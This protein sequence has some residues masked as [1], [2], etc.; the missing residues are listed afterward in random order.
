MKREVPLPG[1]GRRYLDIRRLLRAQSVTQ[2]IE[3]LALCEAAEARGDIGG[4]VL[5]TSDERPDA[6]LLR[7]MGTAPLID[8]EADIATASTPLAIAWSKL[9]S[10][11]LGRL[12]FCRTLPRL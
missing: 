1:N 6:E 7:M 11:W 5:G 10:A 8:P 2:S 12:S 9:A 3:Q 4:E